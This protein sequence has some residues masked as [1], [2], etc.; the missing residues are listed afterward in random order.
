MG[1]S[2]CSLKVIVVVG[3]R[4]GSESEAFAF[5]S[6]TPGAICSYTWYIRRGVENSAIDVGLFS[7]AQ[8]NTI[9][10]TYSLI[11]VKHAFATIS[12]RIRD[13]TQM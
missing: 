8:R 1:R 7:T 3:Y 10:A 11:S 5:Q 13:I 2:G 12:T 6:R 4:W 9:W